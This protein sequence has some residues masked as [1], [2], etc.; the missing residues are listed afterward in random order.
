MVFG[1]PKEGFASFVLSLAVACTAAYI[2]AAGFSLYSGAYVS[3]MS[4]NTTRAGVFLA[5]GLW[6]QGALLAGVIFAFVFGAAIGAV[7]ISVFKK[8][9]QALIL[10]AAG[11]GLGAIAALGVYWQMIRLNDLPRA[12]LLSLAALMGVLNSAVRQVDKVSV[13]LTYITG[14]LAKLGAIIGS[15][16]INRGA[17]DETQNETIVVLGSLWFA[18]VIGAVGGGL[19]AGSYGLKCVLAPA[20]VLVGLG[21]IRWRP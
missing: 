7:I 19:A 9:G 12:S 1:L 18:F 20:A 11:I 15:K 16:I 21:V 13:G 17:G 3:F 2:D 5:K 4:G 6:Q 10:L 14:S 8:R